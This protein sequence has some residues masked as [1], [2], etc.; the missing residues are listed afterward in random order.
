LKKLKFLGSVI[1]SATLLVFALLMT[2]IIPIHV[3][4]NSENSLRISTNWSGGDILTLDITDLETNVT[5]SVAVRLSDLIA[6]DENVPYIMLQAMDI[7]GYRTSAVIKIDN[8]L[9][10]PYV[11]QEQETEE[12]Q[13]QQE[14]IQVI[15]QPAAP[16]P[17][18]I[19]PTPSP[20]PAP[21]APR[22]VSLNELRDILVRERE[23]SVLWNYHDLRM[24]ELMIEHGIALNALLAEFGYD[25]NEVF[26][27]Y[28]EANLPPRPPMLTPDGTGTVVD[29]VMTINDIEF[30]TV[31]STEGSDFFLVI[32]RQR[33]YDNVYLLNA[34]T[35]ADLQALAR[36]RALATGQIPPGFE[37]APPPPQ[38][39]QLTI[40]EI[41][42]A[43]Q[44]ANIAV[45]PAP[46]PVVQQQSGTGVLLPIA[47]MVLL[48]A[49]AAFVFLKL[50]KNT[51]NSHEQAVEDE[52]DDE[53]DGDDGDDYVLDDENIGVDYGNVSDD[54]E[55]DEAEQQSVPNDD[56]NYS[57]ETTEPTEQSLGMG[58][59][60]DGETEEPI[61]KNEE[62][63]EDEEGGYS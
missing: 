59:D 46:A 56:D 3:L 45:Q 50:R 62:N 16:P 38:E 32:D 19:V 39:P 42:A 29:N 6:E 55:G 53:D 51:D 58:G 13:G 36:E 57:N 44:E 4:A 9:Y 41:I 28:R 31:S 10:R 18:Q 60:G 43:I 37:T 40:E 5:Q 22:E 35:E 25:V 30:F 61:Y 11:P 2:F 1:K 54:D 21:T 23:V 14:P 49:G 15:V 27:E 52:Y 20:P 33:P 17:Q 7:L 34:V 12:E 47:G 48:L 8:P 24:T 26:R 63:E